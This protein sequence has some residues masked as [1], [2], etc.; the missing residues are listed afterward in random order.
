M[1]T[2]CIGQRSVARAGSCGR[3]VVVPPLLMCVHGGDR[4]VK[5]CL[6]AKL[7]ES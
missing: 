1:V 2:D 3:V 4:D 7:L 6:M 5:R